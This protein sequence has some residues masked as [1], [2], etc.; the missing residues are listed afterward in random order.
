MSQDSRMEKFDNVIINNADAIRSQDSR[1]EEFDNVIIK[2]ADGHLEVR[3][4][5]E[6]KY[7]FLQWK[8]SFFAATNCCFNL[9]HQFDCKSLIYSTRY[10]CLFGDRRHKGKIKT[11]TG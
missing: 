7:D 10:C 2:N 1:M 11:N 9:T 4:R 5:V 8:D 6:N 3:R